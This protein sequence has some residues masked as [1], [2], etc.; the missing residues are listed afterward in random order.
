MYPWQLI[1]LCIKTAISN[2]N[3]LETS[4]GVLPLRKPFPAPALNTAPDTRFPD[5]PR[6]SPTPGL[7]FLS[8]SGAV[9]SAT[10]LQDVWKNLGRLIS[11]YLCASP[12]SWERLQVASKHRS[13]QFPNIH[14]SIT[15]LYLRGP[16]YTSG[17]M[18]GDRSTG[19]EHID[20]KFKQQL[21]SYDAGIHYQREPQS[22]VSFYHPVFRYG[23]GD[24]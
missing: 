2:S 9:S 23:L 22:I 3:F 21:L 7:A 8:I 6:R 12:S 5:S 16:K 14:T 15:S 13:N 18:T 19:H 24:C 20:H 1:T 4:E 17:T 11:S 10:Q